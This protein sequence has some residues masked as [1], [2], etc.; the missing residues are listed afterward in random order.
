MKEI[1][2]TERSLSTYRN[3][4]IE[5]KSRVYGR[6]FRSGDRYIKTGHRAIREAKPFFCPEHFYTE[7]VD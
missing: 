1:F 5:G 6:R 4:G 7:N 2:L 3:S